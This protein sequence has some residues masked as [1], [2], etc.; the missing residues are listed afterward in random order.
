MGMRT[1]RFFAMSTRTSLRLHDTGLFSPEDAWW[2]SFE[3]GVFGSVDLES[4]F[5]MPESET[6]RWYV[7]L[8]PF[9]VW[10]LLIVAHKLL[11]AHMRSALVLGSLVGWSP[12]DCCRVEISFWCA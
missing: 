4:H 11:N 12:H 7:A 1:R 8:L 5:E 6:C 3:I 10:F 9:G 2:G